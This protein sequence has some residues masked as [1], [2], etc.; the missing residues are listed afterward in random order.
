MSRA[1][2]LS[3]ALGRA[4]ERYKEH[5]LGLR[6][7]WRLPTLCGICVPLHQQLSGG[8]EHTRSEAEALGAADRPVARSACRKRVLCLVGGIEAPQPTRRT[9]GTARRLRACEAGICE[10][11]HPTPLTM[12]PLAIHFAARGSRRAGVARSARAIKLP[13][14]GEIGLSHG[15]S[16]AASRPQHGSSAIRRS[17][18]PQ[19]RVWSA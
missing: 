11:S 8:S 7:L 4:R 14:F 19:A 15:F 18:Q 10:W 6:P 9:E 16:L 12:D 17:S 3:A 13:S 2:P 1:G 5:H